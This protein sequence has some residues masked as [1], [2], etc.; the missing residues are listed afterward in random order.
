MHHFILQGFKTAVTEALYWDSA[1][2]YKKKIRGG[3]HSENSWRSSGTNYSFQ[4]GRLHLF[5]K[6]KMFKT[7]YSIQ[8]W[9]GRQKKV[10]STKNNYVIKNN[11]PQQIFSI[12]FI[13]VKSVVICIWG[14]E[15]RFKNCCGYDNNR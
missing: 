4:N 14:T 1:T 8:Q 2:H 3:R 12:V 7:F 9:E 6:T 13:K 15:Q 5:C 11:V 10:Q